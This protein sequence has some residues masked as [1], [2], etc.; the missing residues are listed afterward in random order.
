MYDFMVNMHL[1]YQAIFG[2]QRPNKEKYIFGICNT[3]HSSIQKYTG[4]EKNE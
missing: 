1:Q 3:G 2:S 4:G